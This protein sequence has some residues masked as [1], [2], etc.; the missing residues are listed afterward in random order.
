LSVNVFQQVP[1]QQLLEDYA[2]QSQDDG[3]CNQLIFS[4]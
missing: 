1:L 4:Y 3:L 2:P